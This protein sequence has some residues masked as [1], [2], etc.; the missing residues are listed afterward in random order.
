MYWSQKYEWYNILHQADCQKFKS[1]TILNVD[2]HV[3]QQKF[4]HPAGEGV[5]WY[6]HFGQQILII[7]VLKIHTWALFS[8]CTAYRNTQTCAQGVMC[9]SVHCTLFIRGRDWK[10]NK[11]PSAVR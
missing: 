2:E 6:N 9:Y 8:R 7:D 11:C 1:L 5:N 3:K 4:S 10:K